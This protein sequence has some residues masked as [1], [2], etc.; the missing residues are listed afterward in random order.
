[1]PVSMFTMKTESENSSE[2]TATSPSATMIER[3][4]ISTG[5]SPAKRAPKTRTQDDE[6]GRQAEGELALLEIRLRLLPEVV[7]GGV[8][9][10]DADLE[11]AAVRVLH[12]LLDLGGI[13]VAA[14][15]DGKQ[16]G[17]P[18]RRGRDQ[19]DVAYDARSVDLDP[20]PSSERV[21]RLRRDVV[22]LRADDDHVLLLA[23]DDPGERP[24]DLVLGLRRLR[25]ALDVSLRAQPVQRGG[26]E[27]ECDQHRSA[28]E[29]QRQARPRR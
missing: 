7:A 6:R 1:M 20:K 25:T 12:N 16:R 23:R 29:R 11:R 26:D 4:A 15:E 28:P 8:V 27:R 22:A 10:G 9:A 19:S 18:V 21:E 3:I 17:V 13:G 2:I 24:G 14:N 5:T